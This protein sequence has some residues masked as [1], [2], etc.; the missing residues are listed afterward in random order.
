MTQSPRVVVSNS[1]YYNINMKIYIFN[2]VILT[3]LVS[4]AGGNF[5]MDVFKA[6]NTFRETPNWI[7]NKIFTAEEILEIRET[8]QSFYKSSDAVKVVKHLKKSVPKL[9]EML[10]NLKNNPSSDLIAEQ[11]N[12]FRKAL[13]ASDI[14][15]LIKT[16]RTVLT[17]PKM[18]KVLKW[19]ERINKFLKTKNQRLRYRE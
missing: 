14:M 11:T 12:I 3:I 5:L 2:V 6:L 19:V 10:Q 17:D 18:A 16:Y 4:I 13:S 1:R 8:F 9:D 15:T 7:I